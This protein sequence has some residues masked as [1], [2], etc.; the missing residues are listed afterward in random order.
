MLP[1]LQWSELSSPYVLLIGG[2]LHHLDVC[3]AFLN[4]LLQEEV[5]MFHLSGFIDS[6]HPHHVC[7]LRRALYGLKQTLQEWYRRLRNFL[8]NVGFLNSLFD[9]SLFVHHRRGEMIIVLVYVNDFVISR[10]YA[11]AIREFIQTVFFEFHYRDLGSLA[12]FLGL[13]ASFQSNGLHISKKK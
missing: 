7:R 8:D 6:L 1:R 3:K 12:Y 11:I 13:E 2:H 4:G 5:Y 10:S 9:S